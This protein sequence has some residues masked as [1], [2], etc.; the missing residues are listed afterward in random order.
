MAGERRAEIDGR[1]MKA[2]FDA[3]NDFG[4]VPDKAGWNRPGLS[5]EDM[6]VRRWFAARMQGEGLRVSMDGAANVSGRLGREGAPCVMLG[7]H[8]D[9][10]PSGGA[11]DGAL[12]VAVALECAL[13]MRDA[14]VPL[15]HP[16]EVVATSEEEGRFGGML[17]SQALAGLTTQEWLE[18]A[19]DADG[20]R[21]TEALASHNLDPAGVMASARPANSVRAFLELHVE[22]G[23][24]L[25]RASIPV[26]IADRVS[27]VVHLGV[28]LRG[29]A[30]HSGTTP[31][32][33]RADAFAGLAEIA[34]GIPGLIS[35]QGTEQSRITIGK[36]E[37]SPN[38]PHTIP[39][40]RYSQSSFGMRKALRWAGC[41]RVCA[42]SS[43]RCR[44]VTG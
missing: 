2:I 36:V 37:L 21:L 18:T 16:I 20:V 23:P 35:A 31:M 41:A 33:M 24:V 26:G 8:L 15:V 28:T 44:S 22:Q 6:A 27:G 13:A 14:K 40:R 29:V 30:N 4:R 3:L 17:G 12:G 42:I 11:F 25:E 39:G 10:V 7:S 5:A 32:D 19:A 34:T 9:T 1:R 43:R 38:F